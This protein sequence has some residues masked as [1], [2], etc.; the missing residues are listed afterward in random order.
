MKQ[1]SCMAIMAREDTESAESLASEGTHIV[2]IVGATHGIG[3]GLADLASAE[4]AHVVNLDVAPSERYETIHFD[5]I[6]PLAAA[7]AADRFREAFARGGIDR[8]TLLIVGHANIGQG[9]LSKVPLDTYQLSLQANAVTPI[10]LAA[11]FLASLPEDVAGGVMLMSSGSVAR[12]IIGQSAYSAAKCAIEGWVRVAREELVRD[13]RNAW[14][15]A[16]RPGFVD[17]PGTR[18]L[19]AEDVAL[20]PRARKLAENVS[21]FAVSIGVGAAR[22]WQALPPP[23]G[24]CILSFDGRAEDG[25]QILG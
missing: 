18:A 3:M 23:S 25:M 20:Y 2:W 8:A 16:V 17:T 10:M 13:G 12:P 5:L 1:I 4:R 11:A 21:R 24:A 6:D 19:A 15:A 9:L 22:I 14:V 7:Q